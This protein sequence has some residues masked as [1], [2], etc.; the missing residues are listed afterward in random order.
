MAYFADFQGFE[1]LTHSHIIEFFGQPHVVVGISGN[2]R[3]RFR[4]VAIVQS[5]QVIEMQ[6]MGLQKVGAQNQVSGDPSIVREFHAECV[7]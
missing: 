4:T 5:S 1:I 2:K 7:I 3:G 6:N